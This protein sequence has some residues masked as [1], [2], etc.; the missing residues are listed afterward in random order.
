MY[1]SRNYEKRSHPEYKEFPID[2]ARYTFLNFGS[3]KAQKGKSNIMMLSVK[4][5]YRYFKVE[6]SVG[7]NGPKTGGESTTLAKAMYSVGV[8]GTKGIVMFDVTRG[9]ELIPA[10]G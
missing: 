10:E 3:N 1:D 6:G 8:E 7:P 4:D 2:S 5:T 9:A